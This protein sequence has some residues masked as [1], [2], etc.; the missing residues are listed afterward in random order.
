[1]CSVGSIVTKS[2]GPS[3]G[4]V[5]IDNPSYMI[6]A[7]F[8]K[9]A[10]AQTVNVGI[11]VVDDE[12]A[13][14]LVTPA[15]LVLLKPV[16][17]LVQKLDHATRRDHAP[18]G[19]F[20]RDG[21]MWRSLGLPATGNEISAASGTLGEPSVHA[22]SADGQPIE[23]LRWLSGPGYTTALVKASD[24]G[25]VTYS[26]YKVTIPKLALSADTWITVRDPGSP[27]LLCQ[28][29]PEGTVFDVPAVL[30]MDC[31]GLD[32]NPFTDWTIWYLD[33]STP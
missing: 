29:E 25:S 6:K 18:V 23:L 30:I 16:T 21:G 7:T 11:T 20:V 12:H 22:T 14:F 13:Q 15:D 26:R 4:T 5:Q 17:V 31:S 3:G 19:L 2:I 32:T 24:G 28:L 33:E 9:G 10:L 1:M 8:P 27:Y